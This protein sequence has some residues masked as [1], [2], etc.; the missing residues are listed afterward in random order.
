MSILV[1]QLAFIC[2]KLAMKTPGQR[3]KYLRRQQ[4]RHQDAV[5]QHI[6]QMRLVDFE[7]INACFVCLCCI[8]SSL[9]LKCEGCPF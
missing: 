7:Q 2:S 9:T 3:G 8:S 5:N 1:S 4:Q 6:S